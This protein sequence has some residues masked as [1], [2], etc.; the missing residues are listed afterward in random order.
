MS[1]NEQKLFEATLKPARGYLEFGA[2]GSTCLAT[3][4]VQ[5]TVITIDSS[6]EWL[7]RVQQSCGQEYRAKLT[8]VHVD[9]GATGEWGYPADNNARHRWPDY[10]SSVW[11]QDGSSDADLYMIDGRFRVACFMQVLLHSQRSSL[12]MIHDFCIRNNYHIIR[13]VAREVAVADSL[14]LFIRRDD[15]NDA[16]AREIL[17]MYEYIPD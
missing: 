8:L 12:I 13:E 3:S 4:L 14:S 10:H 5:G 1:D 15:R 11:R 7:D 2:G 16:H 17:T 9:I 6:Q